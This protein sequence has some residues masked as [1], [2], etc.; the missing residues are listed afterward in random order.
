MRLSVYSLYLRDKI[1]VLNRKWLVP[2]LLINLILEKEFPPGTM[3]Q[4]SCFLALPCCGVG[5]AVFLGVSHFLVFA[6]MKTL[7]RTNINPFYILQIEFLNQIS[8][9][10]MGRSWGN[11]TFLKRIDY[12]MLDNG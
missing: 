5:F 4:L 3:S 1:L 6:A 11:S 8:L 10:V 2:N 7:P 9:G 12:L